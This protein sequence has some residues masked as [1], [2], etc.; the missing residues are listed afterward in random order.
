MA[1]HIDFWDRLDI[2]NRFLQKFVANSSSITD[3]GSV[4]DPDKVL[5]KSN[6]LI[7]PKFV[8]VMSFL[9]PQNCLLSVRRER[10]SSLKPKIQ[11]LN[12][13]DSIQSRVS[14]LL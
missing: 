11:E 14:V 13:I 1:F 4:S 10:P 9:M 8:M 3:P 7:S 6:D 5:S 12:G 2:L